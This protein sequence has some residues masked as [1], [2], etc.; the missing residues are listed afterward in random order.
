M[1][2]TLVRAVSNLWAR[3]SSR[4][5]G[6]AALAWTAG[7]G[8]AGYAI[9]QS[10]ASNRARVMP[11]RNRTCC[12]AAEISPASADLVAT[13]RKIVGDEH[14]LARGGDQSRYTKGQR[15]GEGAALAVVRPG[16]LTEAVAALR[17][18][19]AAGVAIVPQGANTGLTGGSVP[20]D[21]CE[22]P[23]I[24]LSLRRLQRIVPLDGGG[25]VLC[26]AGT[27]IFDLSREVAALGRESHSVLGSLFLNPS[28]AAGV[29][30]GS[31][32]TQL[33]KGPVYTERALYCRVGADGSVELVNA[34]GL[35]LPSSEEELLPA[36]DTGSV[37]ELCSAPDGACSLPASDVEYSERVCMLNHEVSRYNADTTGPDCCR[38]EGKVV[39]LAS[40]HDTFPQP[41]ASSSVWISCKDFEVAQKLKQRVFLH[42]AADLPQSCEY[43]DR[44]TFDV[45][46]ESG[47]ALCTVLSVC[48]IGNTLNNLWQVKQKLE[49]T[50]LPFSH[51]ICDLFLSCI[52]NFCPA[53]LPEALM[54]L[55]KEYDHHMLVTMGEYGSGELKRTQERLSTFLSEQ[56]PSAVTV[57]DFTDPADL[58]KA[59]FFRFAVAPSFTTYCNASGLQGVSIDYAL[60]KAECH[61][62]ALPEGCQ[63]GERDAP[64]RRLRYSHFGCNVVHE[65]LSFSATA[66]AHASKMRIK[67]AVEEMGGKLPAE[68]GHG[69][70]Y[71]AVRDCCFKRGY[72]AEYGFTL[73]LFGVRAAAGNAGAMEEDGPVKHTQPRS[74]WAVLREELFQPES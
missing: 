66:D 8:S 23:S 10:D 55:G 7:V 12:E 59:T 53:P 25:K 5:R 22:R 24:V 52:N 35:N 6:A 17:A 21:E 46:N 74:G 49:A 63:E 57:Y 72:W 28:V 1:P 42:S 71:T 69:T 50:R 9:A 18:C 15:L 36:L 41:L 32:G 65:D 19:A 3:A 14:V 16:N 62:P 31:G 56:A 54:K 58:S 60:P 27:G 51:I 64:V 70:E 44:D 26:L 61:A 45:V 11:S 29:S 73:V 67:H 39:I 38:C 40:V 30:F 48:G 33:R 34:L 68:H 4:A 37:A 43:M 2:R 20:R 13:L 47:R